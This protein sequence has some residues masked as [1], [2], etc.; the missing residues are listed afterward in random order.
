MNKSFYLFLCFP[1]FLSCQTDSV[2]KNIAFSEYNNE[3]DHMVDSQICSRDIINKDVISALRRVPRHVFIPEHNQ[4]QAYRDHPV[5]IGFS[6][7]ISQPYIVAYMTQAIN[8]KLNQRVL[9]IGTGSGYQAA[10]LAELVDT[11]YTIEIISDLSKIAQNICQELGYKNINYRI[12]DGYH[13]WP[14]KAPFDA[15]V[16][17]AAPGHIP[18]KLVDQLAIGGTMIIPVG[19]NYQ[20]LVVIK[21]EENGIVQKSVMSVRFVPMTGDAEK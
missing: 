6:Q 5:R 15:I 4:Y 19:E 18:Q 9:E 20:E 8:P 17:T 10:V 3:R 16:V 12:G 11:V 21:K 2:K 13:G 1:L 7:T 14:E